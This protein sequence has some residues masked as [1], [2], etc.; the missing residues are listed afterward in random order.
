M[1]IGENMIRI[2]ERNDARFRRGVG[3]DRDGLAAARSRPVVDQDGFFRLSERRTDRY[4]K[5]LRDAGRSKN[6]LKDTE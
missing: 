2:R 3:T 5:R 4:S 6:E 1:P